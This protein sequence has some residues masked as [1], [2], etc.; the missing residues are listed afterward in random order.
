M[1]KT[2]RQFLRSSTAVIALPFL[3][4]FGF[5]RFAS[6]ASQV[7]TPPKRMIFLGTGFGVTAN[8]WYPD[9]N[10]TGYDYKLPESLT[11]LARH[12]QDISI[13]QH[14]EHANSRDGHSGSTFWLTGAD[15]FA[16]PGRN[17]HNT[18]SVDQVAAAQFGSQT[19]YTSMHVDGSDLLGHGAGSLS[20]N[21]N[22]KPILGLQN[23]VALYHK[24]FSG[25]SIPLAQRQAMLADERSALDT[26]LSDARSVKRGLTQTDVEKLDEYFESIRDIEKRIGKEESWLNVP[27]KTPTNPVKEPSESLEG[28]PAVEAVYDLMVAAMQVDA[29]RV[30]TYRLPSDSFCAS[31]GS[32]YT[33]HNLSHYAGTERTHD[34]IRRDQAHARLV[35]H[36]LDKLKATTEADGSTLL[37]NVALTFGSNLRS[38][39]SLDNCPTLIAGGGAGFKQGRHLVMKDEKT[40]LCNLWLSTLRGSGVN[41]DSFGDATGVIDELFEA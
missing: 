3:E 21:Q 18:V 29:S 9:K 40:P 11:P 6:A 4:S 33:A 14:L 28:A 41:V 12:K 23:P 1:N 25:D 31:I 20:W 15:R 22:G 37:D 19:R 10:D 38:K 5:R 34:S 32:S 27:K 17:F 16:I 26:V 13:L 7:T 24:L 39:H 8:A 36:L 35:A 2:R 30:F